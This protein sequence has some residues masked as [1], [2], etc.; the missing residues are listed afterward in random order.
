MNSIKNKILKTL[1]TKKGSWWADPSFG[2]DLSQVKKINQTTATE[3]ENLIHESL[4]WMIRDGEV[5]DIKVEVQNS[6][7][8]RIDYRI[9]V[10]D[11]N[12]EGVLN[13]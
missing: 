4:F 11:I 8:N 13:D 3:V 12:I 10:Q 7:P 1:G 5:E 9:T 6:E 2:T